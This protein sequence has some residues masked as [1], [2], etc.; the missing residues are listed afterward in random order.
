MIIKVKAS[1]RKGKA[2]KA[3]T[4]T[5]GASPIAKARAKLIRKYTS[6][7]EYYKNNGGKFSGKNDAQTLIKQ[8]ALISKHTE[9]G[10]RK[11]AESTGYVGPLTS[12]KFKGVQK[13]KREMYKQ[14]K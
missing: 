3:Y 7:E 13:R 2:V 8:K 9:E 12:A 6:G 1:T 5:T 4:R 14:M 10:L 11:K